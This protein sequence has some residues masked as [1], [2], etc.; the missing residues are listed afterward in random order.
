MMHAT[1]APMATSVPHAIHFAKRRAPAVAMA[2]VTSQDSVYV[3]VAFSRSHAQSTVWS[4]RRATVTANAAI[5]GD[6]YV[7]TTGQGNPVITAITTI[8]GPTATRFA[9]LLQRAMDTAAAPPPGN[10]S[11]RVS[12]MVTGVTC[13]VMLRLHVVDLVNALPQVAVNV[14]AVGPVPRVTSAPM[15]T[16]VLHAIHFAKQRRLAEAMVCVTS[17]DSVYVPVNTSPTRAQ[18]TVWTLRRA[19]V[20]ANVTI[21]GNAYASILFLEQSVPNVSPITL[22]LPAARF[23]MLLQRVTGT[24][25][26]PPQGNASVWKT[27]MVKGVPYTAMLL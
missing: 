21:T 25:A 2:Y 1:N 15:T 16:L 19:T 18:S 13:T 27:T 22:V 10:A 6:A 8:T 26:A 12:T 14:P 9:T 23:A 4:L 5:L 3:Q 7:M 20:M 11:V 17:R 24:A